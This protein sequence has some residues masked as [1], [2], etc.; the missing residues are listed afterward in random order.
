MF[1][2]GWKPSSGRQGYGEVVQLPRSGNT[3]LYPDFWILV[4]ESEGLNDAY[5]ISFWWKSV[6]I[7][8][9][10]VKKLTQWGCCF[11]GTTLAL[12]RCWPQ[13]GLTG[14]DIVLFIPFSSWFGREIG[15]WSVWI[16]KFLLPL[17]WVYTVHLLAIVGE[18]KCLN[19]DYLRERIAHIDCLK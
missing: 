14:D 13:F 10:L 2:R 3:R 16:C 8:R 11:Q 9:Q 4:L 19:M 15:G 1:L 12:S 6:A 5:S 17:E 7:Q 18:I